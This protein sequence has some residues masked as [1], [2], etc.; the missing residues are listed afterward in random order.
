MNKQI[1][2]EIKIL[3]TR[4][5]ARWNELVESNAWENY[6]EDPEV[7]AL[8]RVIEEYGTSRTNA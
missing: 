2:A 3:E 8:Y 7:K 5:A 1:A 6:E 4:R